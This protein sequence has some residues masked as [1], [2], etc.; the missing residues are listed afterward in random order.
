MFMIMI[1]NLYSAKTTEEYKKPL[2]IKVKIF[3]TK[4]RINIRTIPTN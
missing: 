4:S 3:K 2:Y 1:M